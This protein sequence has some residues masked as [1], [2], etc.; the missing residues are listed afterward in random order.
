MTIVSPAPASPAAAASDGLRA[1]T[2]RAPAAQADRTTEGDAPTTTTT[3]SPA[4]NGTRNASDRGRQRPVASVE[5]GVGR[6]N[7]TT[8][9]VLVGRDARMKER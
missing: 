1:A 8:P 6:L 4:S 3:R 5:G 9:T 7:R 2:P